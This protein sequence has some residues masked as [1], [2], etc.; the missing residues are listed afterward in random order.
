WQTRQVSTDFATVQWNVTQKVY[1]TGRAQAG[2]LY[3][4]GESFLKVKNVKLLENGKEVAADLHPSLADK[5]RATPFKK[6]MFFYILELK[7]YDPTAVYILQADIAGATG[8][9]TRGNITFNLSPSR[10]FSVV[11]LNKQ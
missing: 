2:F 5:Y 9:D 7:K 8:N 10:P 6:D 11:E 4:S 1:T 3:T